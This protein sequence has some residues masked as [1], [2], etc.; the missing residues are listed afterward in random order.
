LVR[1]EVNYVAKSAKIK[2]MVIKKNGLGVEV[3]LEVV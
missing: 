2:A 3:L 1:L